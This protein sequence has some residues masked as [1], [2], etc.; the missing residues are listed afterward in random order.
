MRAAAYLC[1]GGSGRARLLYQVYRHQSGRSHYR[2]WPL[3]WVVELGD[4]NP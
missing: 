4:L 2:N 1:G 3:T